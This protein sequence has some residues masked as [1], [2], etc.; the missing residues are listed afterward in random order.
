[1]YRFEKNY[2]QDPSLFRVGALPDRCYYIPCASREEALRGDREHSSRLLL[3]NGLWKFRYYDALRKLD[4][5][6]ESPI[7]DGDGSGFEQIPVPSVW[8]NYGYDHHHY[9]N[10]AYPFPYDPPYVPADNPCGLY[11]RHFSLEKRAGECYTLHFE[12]V[13]SCFYLYVN[14]RFAGYGQVSHCTNAFDITGLVQDGENTLTVLVLKW[15][16]GSYLEDQDKFRMSGI[17]RDVYL[18]KRPENHIWDYTV[19]TFLEKDAARVSLDIFP[20]GELP[21]GEILLLDAD[22][23]VAVQ[24]ALASH[25]ELLLTHPRL[26]NA[27]TPNLY[28]L[29]LVTPQE[30]IPD[31]VGVREVSVKEGVLLLN[32][33]PIKLKGVNRHD[34]Y[35]DTGYTASKEQLLTD[36]RLMKEHNINAI[37]TSHYPNAPE[38]VRLCSQY[39][40]YLMDEAD[41]ESHGVIAANP[42]PSLES[43]DLLAADPRFA[44][45]FLDRVQRMVHRDKNAPSVLCWSMGNE[46]GYGPNISQAAYW[47]KRC[48][49]TRLVHYES[50]YGSLERAKEWDV[51]CL[52]VYADMYNSVESIERHFLREE[53]T[54]LPVT[55]EA[56]YA[57]PNH[58]NMAKDRRKKPLI[59]SE[60]A[61]AMGNGPGDL[62]DYW[63]LFYRED[64]I[65]GGFVWEWCDHAPIR[66]EKDGRPLYGYGGDFGD[67]PNAGN[68]CMDGLVYPDRTPHTGLKELKNVLRPI[69]ASWQDGKLF[70]TSHWDY[71]EGGQMAQ[72]QWTLEEDGQQTAQGLLKDFALPPRGSC[73]LDL[74]LPTAGKG[75]R[76]RYLL[77]RYLLK[78]D[79]GLLKAGHDLGFDQLELPLPLPEEERPGSSRSRLPD[80]EV[81]Q[82]PERF[83]I[84]GAGFSYTF[85]RSTGIFSSLCQSGQELLVRPMEYNI[86]RA[87][88]DNDRN[89]L[90]LWSAYGIDRAFPRVYSSEIQLR[91]HLV[92]VRAEIGLCAVTLSNLM[93]I[94]AVYTIDT[95]GR[96]TAELECSVLPSLPDLPRFGVRLF[97]PSEVQNCSYFGYGPYE[98]YIDKHHHTWLSRFT[99]TASQMFED[100]IKPQEN[101]SHY[102]CR[103]LSVTDGA[104]GLLFCSDTPFSFSFMEYTQE[105]LAVK[106]HRDELE[107]AGCNVLCLDYRMGGLGSASCGEPINPRYAFTEKA[108][109]FRFAIQPLKRPFE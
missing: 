94:H 76:S 13:D 19:Q 68:F 25:A 26:W 100:Y 7:D 48:D 44:A 59:M 55:P 91:H 21:A 78:A 29:L 9:T 63:Q 8:Q 81:L 18:L 11:Q 75:I 79:D 45:A 46:S 16:D 47:T 96:I 104:G 93:Q 90:S 14:H 102:G 50:M 67:Y 10:S 69:R 87:P 105:E 109:V 88:I 85:D 65:A 4:L 3:L 12:G 77:L 71:R 33:S 17:F 20:M 39:G 73:S 53:P 31:L 22:G 82:D 28:T 23:S 34:S 86:M 98:S 60:Y 36:L 84:A 72:I 27:E 97:L 51:D 107:K 57:I 62:E 92:T 99:S 54:Q 37:R 24:T 15:C 89:L 64:T 106:G 83:Q 30:V 49:P 101:S 66:G 38:M 80:P 52:D 32:G 56:Y 58:R 61:H 103:D 95:E 108:F 40:F 41:V 42:P 35:P 43:Y 6:P 1:M 2:H 5:D 74:P 70:L